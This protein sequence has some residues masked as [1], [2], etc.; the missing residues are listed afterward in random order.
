MPRKRTQT[1]RKTRR[2]RGSGILDWAK[3]AHQTIRSNNGYSKG[4][5]LAYN[6]WG[7]SAVGQKLS[8]SNAALVNKGVA[9]GLAKL[10][11]SGYGLSRAGNGLRR[12]GMGAR[13][14]Y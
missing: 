9:L 14:K 3:K 11:Q 8:K 7:K 5:S 4:L 2:R 12:S 1:K 6:K 10:R 13:L